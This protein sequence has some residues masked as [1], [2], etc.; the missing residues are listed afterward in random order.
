M[1]NRKI[2]VSNGLFIEITTPKT[3]RV[4]STSFP[5]EAT[6]IMVEEISSLIEALALAKT[7]M[8]LEEWNVV[9]TIRLNDWNEY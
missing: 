9:D 1:S 6:I 4:W 7:I 5:N 3:L 8:L 2:E